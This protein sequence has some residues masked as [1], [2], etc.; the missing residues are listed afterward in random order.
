MFTSKSQLRS[1]EAYNEGMRWS[2]VSVAPAWSM[3]EPTQLITI[4]TARI[5]DKW[6]Q[7]V[8]KRCLLYPNTR[9]WPFLPV[10]DPPKCLS[11]IQSLI[12]FFSFLLHLASLIISCL[13]ISNLFVLWEWLVTKDNRKNQTGKVFQHG[14]NSMRKSGWKQKLSPWLV[15]WTTFLDGS[16]FS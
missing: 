5:M 15:R 7:D 3:L 16:T 4:V 14:E 12:L 2:I 10:P 9:G 13:A 8:Q 6:S 1:W 11:S